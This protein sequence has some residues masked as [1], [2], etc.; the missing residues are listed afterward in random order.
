V[1]TYHVVPRKVLAGQVVD[2][3][4]AETLNGQRL[5]ISRGGDGVQVDGAN[6]VTTDIECSNGVIHVIDRV[7]TPPEPAT[8]ASASPAASPTARETIIE[9]IN[10]GVPN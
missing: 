7:L 6:V 9:A 4:S 2:L 8:G 3:N 1:L 10:R 5:S